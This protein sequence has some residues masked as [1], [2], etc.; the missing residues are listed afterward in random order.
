MQI[1]QYLKLESAVKILVSEVEVL[2]DTCRRQHTFIQDL[3]ELK[4][5]TASKAELHAAVSSLRT[6]AHLSSASTDDTGQQDVQTIEQVRLIACDLRKVKESV[7]RLQEKY[8][9][10]STQVALFLLHFS[11]CYNFLGWMLVGVLS[12][13]HIRNGK[14]T[15]RKQ[16]QSCFERIVGKSTSSGIVP[17]NSPE[18]RTQGSRVQD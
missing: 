8:S 1:S 2:K 13:Q 5:T 10:D 3:Y 14:S 18:D 12:A 6:R 16:Y 4:N 9:N 15:R 17:R 11:A 7:A